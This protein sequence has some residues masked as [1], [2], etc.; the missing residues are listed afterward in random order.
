MM[1]KHVKL[2]EEAKRDPRRYYSQAND[3][4][5]DRRLNDEERLEILRSWERDARGI[6]VASDENMTGGEPPR[7]GEVSRALS[8]VER[9]LSI[10][11]DECHDASKFGGGE[12]K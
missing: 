6:S 7:L 12:D 10:N 3:V 4:L 2:V 8:E 11:K 1:M 9:R 5:R